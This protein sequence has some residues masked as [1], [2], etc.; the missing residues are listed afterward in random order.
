M[1]LTVSAKSN[2]VAI[3]CCVMAFPAR[4]QLKAAFSATNTSACGLLVT[5]FTD[6]STGNPVSWQWDLGNGFTSREQHPSASYVTGGSY[7]VK[8]TVTDA[9]GA[10]NTI[11]KENYINV[12][13]KPAVKFNAIPPAGCTPFTTTFTDGSDPGSGTIAKVTWD[14]GDG[15]I[16]SGN[17]IAHT[18]NKAGKYAITLTVTNSNGCTNFARVDS[19]V[20]AQAPII[21]DFIV[22]DKTLCQAPADV[23][24]TNTSVGGGKL[25][26]LWTFDDGTTSTEKDPGKHT[27]TTPGKH[28]IT[29]NV[30]NDL[31]CS[32]TKTISDINIANYSTDIALPAP[33][34]T[35]TGN[36]FK[37]VLSGINADNYSWEFNGQ[38]YGGNNATVVYLPAAAGPLKVKLTA[39]YGKC[40]QV[41]EKLVTVNTSPT[42]SISSD[43]KPVCSLP[44]IVHFNDNA[45][46]AAS[47]LWDFGDQQTS[48]E[49]APAH[50]YAAPGLYKVRL[51]TANAAGCGTSSEADI[52]VVQT[53]ITATANGASGCE[54]IT[55][56]FSATSN[57][58][59]AISSYEWDF[60]DGSPR[61][62]AANPSHA[63]PKA[64]TYSVSLTYTTASGCKGTVKCNPDITV[65]KK[66][67]IDFSSPDIPQVCGNT[68]VSFKDLSDVGDKWLWDFGDNT[69]SEGNTPTPKHA[70]S[71]PGTYDIKLTVWNGTCSNTL[72]KPQYIKAIDP[73]PRFSILNPDCNNRLTATFIENS[74]QATSWKWEWGDGTDTSYTT[75]VARLTHK[76]SRTGKYQVRLTITYGG[77]TTVLVRT[78]DMIAAS[79]VTITADKNTL[80]SSDIITA[81]A[82]KYDPDIYV[83]NSFAWR[84]NGKAWPDSTQTTYRFS[85]LAPGKQALQLLAVNRVGCIDSSNIVNIQ[86]RGP[87]AGYNTPPQ[88]Q[89][90]GT[91]VTFTDATDLTYSS[92]IVKWEWDFGDG[93]PVKTFTAP[94]FTHTYYTAGLFYPVLR[95]TNKEGCT[96][97]FSGKKIQVN[98]PNAAFTADKNI[99][100]PGANVR[101]TNR[102]V[103]V[104]GKIAT[105]SWD[106]GNGTTVS[107]SDNPVVN[108]PT[109]GLY[110]VTLIITD[111]NGCTDTTSQQIKVA[112]TGAAFTYT[113]SFVDGGSCAP[114]VFRFTNKS[115][116][117]ISSAWDFGDGSTSDQT[118]PMHTYILAGKYK[119][120][121]KVKGETGAEDQAE[122]LITVT[123]PSAEITPSTQ[124]GC[125]E[126]EVVFNIVN[127]SAATFNWDFTDG[128]IQESKDTV[129]THLFKT[130]G[131][132]NPRLLLTDKQGCKGVAFL[133]SP[134]VIDQLDV[135]LNPSATQICGKGEL[136]FAPVFTSQAMSLGMPSTYKW[137][138]DPSV[139]ATGANTATPKFYLDK[140]GTYEFSLTTTTAYLC[141]KTVSAT[142][143]VYPAPVASITGPD[144]ACKDMPVG[145][146]GNSTGMTAATWKWNF[147]DSG[148]DDKQLPADHAFVVPGNKDVTLTV[149]SKDGCTDTAHH[150]INILP[151]PDARATSFSEFICQGNTT[152]LQAS[153]GAQYEWTPAAGLSNPAIANPQASPATTT[154]YLVKVTDNNG[155]INTAAVNVRVV[156]PFTVKATPDTA[157]CLGD[158]L[159]LWVTGADSYQWE[160]PGLDN[161]SSAVPTATLNNAGTYVYKVT[162]YDKDGC[163]SENTSLQVQ[164]HPRPTVSL[165]ADMQAMASVPV[166]LGGA[167]SNDVVRWTWSPAEYLDCSSCRSVQATPN[168]TTRYLLEVENRFGCKASDDIVIHIT[169][170]QGA[171]FMPNAF[172]PNNDGQN[173]YCYPKGRGVKEIEYL[174]I[175]DRW[176]TLV[177]E[178]RHFPINVPGSGWDGKNR[179]QVAPIGTYIYSLKTICESGESFEFKGNITLIR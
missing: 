76:Y 111:S 122:E 75:R 84:V 172:T 52:Q 158:K 165:G 66:P 176:G 32:A 110:T 81:T 150:M 17:T 173:E 29:L 83:A 96:N 89:C 38:P 113:S 49:K 163:F 79:P 46:G 43:N 152:M 130:P 99:V 56:G 177:F 60:G 45:T 151:L 168:I 155:C 21:A 143:V 42:A 123:G 161:T 94:P 3:L 164:L 171:V 119:V 166:T 149:T 148:T 101:F 77:C 36:I 144:K 82:S 97:V 179:G 48:G 88:V 136:T 109:P 62:A 153:G 18:F 47:W 53:I 51:T 162:G 33:V 92:N 57:S 68:V 154:D 44:A 167:V 5:N 106:F 103:E 100:Q 20:E 2:I 16:G 9:S 138:Y 132:Y 31:G 170:S 174:R 112:K 95:V 93:T 121:L 14:F 147:G 50:S 146:K 91:V 72:L 98:G 117:Y 142:V 86:V 115:F 41:V 116:N 118:N 12:W 40:T 10:S 74:T 105:T 27:F 80:C 139:R 85:N 73:F 129:I 7:T 125:L 159:P 54:G 22:A 127:S 15:F 1:N 131:I 13:K 169:C 70:Y 145:F 63:Y 4:A 102:S 178:N 160:G 39:T 26:Y 135:K 6:Q 23:T 108:Y 140:P 157:L 134:I 90:R 71:N 55:P 114:M 156:Q 35:G 19:A 126:K 24:I 87:L 133:A 120:T 67:V 8:L 128:I 58:S 59:D 25:S 64:G 141:E 61:S 175:Y 30:T 104:G 69:T 37:A 78:A 28:A 107:N 65:F 137:T 11:V 124:G 34:C